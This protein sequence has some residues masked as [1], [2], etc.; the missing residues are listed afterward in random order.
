[1][2]KTY[3]SQP[4]DEIQFNFILE[5]FNAMRR[6]IDLQIEA[7]RK[8]EISGAAAS[9]AIVIWLLANKSYIDAIENQVVWSIPFLLSLLMSLKAFGILKRTIEIA[10]YIKLIEKAII[11]NRAPYGWHHFL[12]RK[13]LKS[14]ISC[15][16][17]GFI[18]LVFWIFLLTL[19]G[20]LFA[21]FG[22]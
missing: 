16:F 15:R 2:K 12:D 14:P 9:A 13:K 5:E 4:S 10:E 8:I 11:Q 21:T 22:K 19:H 6:E 7:R 17:E 20:L 3:S 18:S 1:M